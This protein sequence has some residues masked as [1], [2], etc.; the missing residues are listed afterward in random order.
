M[1]TNARISTVN[2]REFPMK[3]KT[4][5]SLIVLTCL[6]TLN[7][8]L[9][10]FAQGSAF[11][12]QGRLA[13]GTNA[14]AG[15]YDLRF[16]I[17]DSSAG[18]AAVGG[19]LTSSPVAVSNGFFTVTLDFGAGVFNGAERWIEIDVRPNGGGAFT[20]LSP[21]Q[22][23]A[24]TPYAMMSGNLSGAL[25]AMQLTGT[26]DDGRL[27]PNVALLNRSQTFIGNNAFTRPVGIGV[28]MP[29]Q[30]LS[31]AGGLNLDQSNTNNGSIDGGLTFGSYSGE[32]IASRRTAGGAQYGLDFYTAFAHRMTIAWNG[33]VGIGTASPGYLLHLVS[34]LGAVR[35]DST[36][37]ALGS[38]LELRNT[39]VSPSYL[40][41]INFNNAA[42]TFPGQIGYFANHILAFRT[43]GA[44]RMELSGDG[45]LSVFGSSTRGV[46]AEAAANNG[47]GIFGFNGAAGTASS[48]NGYTG[49]YGESANVAGNGVVGVANAGASAYGV[50]G[51][52]TSGQGGV[53][54]GGNYGIRALSSGTA[55]YFNN[56]TVIES[57]SGINKPQ[58]RLHETQDG[59]FARLEF[60][61]GNRAY[62]HIAVGGG[63]ANQ[64]NFYNSTNGDVMSL[65]QDGT[66]F[67]KV[68][69]ITGGADIAEP[70]RMSQENLPKGA[71]VVI[72]EENPGKLKLSAEAYDRRV[73]GII[74]GAGGVT[75]GLSLQQKGVVDGDQH[76]ALS[77]RVYVQA[78][79]AGGAIKPGDL[80]TTAVTPGHAMK[81]ADYARAQGAILGKAMTGLKEGK[82]LVLVLVTLQ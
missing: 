20:T 7:F 35:V 32:G 14:A 65:T 52:S 27:S 62:W 79:A 70:F 1:K 51:K 13:S 56:L 63:A 5:V 57:D 3:T 2:R 49:V 38:V 60:Q 41:A 19:P 76:V 61:A 46:F 31:V 69:T 24:A 54:D 77:G 17:Y 21:R 47:I 59:D 42:G 64:M 67:A 71:V 33:N 55:A 6:S 10:T 18:P 12:Y 37:N 81:A 58:L 82:G 39:M 34:D 40:G 25:P 16:T 73:A 36:G 44:Q 15:T 11:T 72:D 74:S 9:S 68:L 23:I 50:W 29:Q 53:F 30:A 8:Q 48:G 80:L 66:L 22:K 43:A 28:G 75:P 4:L 45:R 78:D 26:L